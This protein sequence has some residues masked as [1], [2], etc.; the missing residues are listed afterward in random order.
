MNELTVKT[1]DFEKAKAALKK[2][3]EEIPPSVALQSFAT[4]GGLFDL[5]EH[6]VKGEELNKLTAQIQKNIISIY[7]LINK[8]M[9]EFGQVYN[10]FEALDKDY[11]QFILAAIKAADEANNKAKKSADKAEK[12][13]IDI[14]KTIEVQKKTITVLAQFKE[15]LNKLEHLDKIDE[16]WNDTQTFENKIASLNES[17]HELRNDVKE[18]IRQ[19]N[20]LYAQLDKE[21][22][23]YNEQIKQLFKQLKLS[24]ILAGSSIG[25][26][27]MSIVLSIL[28][29][30]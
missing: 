6:T 28:G 8:S 3:S 11:F 24:Y 20:E 7:S 30:I 2:F 15:Q 17:I 18:Q 21:R 19:K 1:H 9:K 16:I 13:S 4:S 26:A 29:V 5:F 27:L 25:V 23:P 10:A 12:N 22:M 14:I